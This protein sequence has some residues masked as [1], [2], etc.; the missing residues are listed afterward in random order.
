[1]TRRRPWIAFTLPCGLL[2]IAT[3]ASAECAWVL[4]SRATVT[5]RNQLVIR[6]T[7]VTGFPASQEC[8]TRAS[9]MDMSKATEAEKKGI[10]G[11]G[12]QSLDY[13]CLPDTVDPRGPKRK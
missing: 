6:W 5:E 9:S 11:L 1:M 10:Q 4:W 7:P 8:E 3:S 13:T 12:I 2:A